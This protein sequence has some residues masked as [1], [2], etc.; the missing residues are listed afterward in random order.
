VG[1]IQKEDLVAHSWS[2]VMKSPW[3]SYRLIIPVG[4]LIFLA[5]ALDFGLGFNFAP[6]H[7]TKNHPFATSIKH[8]EMALPHL[9]DEAVPINF[10]WITGI[11][12]LA[13]GIVQLNDR[14]RKRHKLFHRIIGFCYI[15]LGSFVV[16]TGI[17]F[18]PNVLGGKA[19]QIAFIVLAALWYFTAGKSIYHAIRGNYLN[20]RRWAIQ[21]YILTLASGFIRPLMGLFNVLTPDQ[22]PETIFCISVWM[23]VLLGVIISQWYVEKASILR[24]SK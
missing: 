16:G 15:A 2:A 3:I 13:A 14:I 4:L 1:R 5:F 6:E 24:L 7:L 9:K 17:Y 12:L 20:H 21:N 19:T 23:A 11:F 10:H 8:Y 22:T 18:S